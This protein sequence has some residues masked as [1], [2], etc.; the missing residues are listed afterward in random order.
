VSLQNTFQVPVVSPYNAK[1]LL[2]QLKM[3]VKTVDESKKDNFNSFNNG[4]SKQLKI[5]KKEDNPW[6][7][8]ASFF[9][10]TSVLS[11][12]LIFYY[13]QTCLHQFQKQNPDASISGLTLAPIP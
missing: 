6:F 13:I 4:L 2:F 1:M 5:V 11:S 12:S 9:I 10:H 7:S 3:C 8:G